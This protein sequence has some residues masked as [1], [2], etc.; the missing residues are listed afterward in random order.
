MCRCGDYFRIQSLLKVKGQAP[1]QQVKPG[2][3]R[4]NHDGRPLIFSHDE[5]AFLSAYVITHTITI[6]GVNTSLEKSL[7]SLSCH[8]GKYSMA[9]LSFSLGKTSN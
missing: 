4:A 3:L 1:G 6:I 8:I 2:V 7:T 5:I 9:S